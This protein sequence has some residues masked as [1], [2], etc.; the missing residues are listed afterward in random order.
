MGLES[1]TLSLSDSGFC[2]DVP[3]LPEQT[4]QQHSSGQ[5]FLSSQMNQMPDISEIPNSVENQPQST[6]NN[7]VNNG[8]LDG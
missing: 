8:L 4:V 7:E 6:S 3:S 1:T 2:S 5:V